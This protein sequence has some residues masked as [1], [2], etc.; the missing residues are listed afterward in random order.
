MKTDLI[1][2]DGFIRYEEIF[3]KEFRRYLIVYPSA[4]KDVIKIK[5]SSFWYQFVP[6][7]SSYFDTFDEITSFIRT[8]FEFIPFNDMNEIIVNEFVK[9]YH[10]FVYSD[11][12]NVIHLINV[13]KFGESVIKCAIEQCQFLALPRNKVNLDNIKLYDEFWIGAIK[14]QQLSVNFYHKYLNVICSNI[15][16]AKS[17]RC[18]KVFHDLHSSAKHKVIRISENENP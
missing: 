1:T 11:V 14:K 6:F 17:L 3:N 5:E 18:I 7:I 8:F 16:F 10:S 2:I 15:E 9:D 12:K 13:Y 4:T